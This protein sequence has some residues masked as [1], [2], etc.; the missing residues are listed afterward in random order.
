MPNKHREDAL[1][2]LGLLLQLQKRAQMASPAE[3]P[4]VLVNETRGLVAYRQAVLW[5]YGG[6]GVWT[7]GAV[8]GLAAPEQGAPFVL[9]LQDLAKTLERQNQHTQTGPL[10]VDMFLAAQAANWNEWLPPNGFWLPLVQASKLVGALALFRD[11]PFATAEQE[12]LEHLGGCYGLCLPHKSTQTPLAALRGFVRSPRKRLWLFLLVF[13]LLWLP[14]RQSVL[15]P[16]E[17]IAVQPVHIR[18]GLDGVIQQIFVEPNQAVRVG[19]PLAALEDDQLQT[20][21][22]VAQKSMEIATAELQQHQ[23]L[24]LA[25]PR[26]KI[27]L[28][29]LQGRVEQLAAEL[30]LVRS[31]L[32]RVVIVSPAEGIALID[33]PDMWLGRPVSL[34]QKIMELA[35]P[36]AVQL[37]ISLP[38]GESLPLKL[39]DSLVFFPNIAPHAP[40][41]AQLRYVGYQ[42]SEHPAT[43]LAF[44]LRAA[45]LPDQ[46]LPRLGL[47]GTAK[48]YGARSPLVALILRKPLLQVRQWLGL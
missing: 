39:G 32:E 20:R 7:V 12:L 13:A 24:S 41:E 18:A 43:G 22:L 17:V 8:S 15:A 37:E 44:T 31:Q 35:K 1:L 9:W 33:N 29:M 23:Q 47:R 2:R 10:R 40:L 42:A 46:P 28:P 45:F 5:H 34:G 48:L 27:R 38:M 6:K 26:S 21:L 36:D 3:L 14:V 30:A 11:Q 19:T 16:A 4:F 25:D